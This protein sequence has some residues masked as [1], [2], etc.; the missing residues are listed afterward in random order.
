MNRS[1]F[2][3]YRQ[4]RLDFSTSE[5]IPAI[6]ADFNPDEFADTLVKAHVN[7]IT[8]F[9]APITAGSTSCAQANPGR[10]HPHLA[11][12]RLLKEQIEACRGGSPA[13]IYTTIQWDRSLTASS[14]WLCSDETGRIVGTPPFEAGFYRELN[15]NS[16]YIEQFIKPHVAEID[17]DAAL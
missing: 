14:E 9:H 10:I 6:G 13:P 11:R 16:P 2:L 5:D 17:G 15:V 7:S 12:P 4:I 1:N 8:C 3:P